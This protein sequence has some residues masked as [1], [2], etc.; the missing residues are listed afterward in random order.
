MAWTPMQRRAIQTRG[1]N[2]IVSAGA[3]SGKTAVLSERILEYC[4]DGHDIRNVLV[5]TF[6]NAAAL[7][8]KERIRQK[9]LTHHLTDQASYIDSA[10]I[11]TFDAYSL[12][13]VK[14]YY[15]H[16]GIEKDVSVIDQSLLEVQKIKFLDRLF[17]QLYQTKNSDFFDLLKKYAKQNDDAVKKMVFT[18]YDKLILEVDEEAF[19]EHYQEKYGTNQSIHQCA[20]DYEKLVKSKIAL[21]LQEVSHL[22]GLCDVE[23][24][25]RLKEFC[26]STIEKLSCLNQYESIYNA[27]SSL[28]FPRVSPKAS[29]AVKEQKKKCSDLLKSIQETYLSKYSTLEASEEELQ[30]LQGNIQFLFKLVWMLREEIRKYEYQQNAFDYMDIAKMAIDLVTKNEQVHKDICSNLEEILIDEYQDTSDIQEAF[31]QAIS[32]HNCMMV[33]DLKQSIY[34]FRNANPYIFKQ[35]Y[36]LYSEDI[37]GIKLDLTHN[38]RSRKEVLEDI[39]LIFSDLMTEACGDVNYSVNHQMHFGQAAYED[40]KAKMDYHLDVLTYEPDFSFSDEEV[41]AFI[42]ANKIKQMMNDQLTCLGKQGFRPVCYQDFAILID[43]TK[44]FVTFKKVFEYVGIPLAIEADLDLNNSIL[45]RL[46]ANL[47]NL[48]SK[49]CQNQFDKSYHH[50]LCSIGRSF[51]FGYSDNEIYRLAN[52]EHYENELTRK[53]DFLVGQ[54]NEISLTT[55][56]HQLVEQFDIYE[57][58]PLIGDVENSCVVLEYIHS[59]F[60]TMMHA[61]MDIHEASEYLSLVIDEGIALKYKLTNKSSDSVRIMTIHKSKGLEFPFC[62]FPMLSS[63]F[64]Q[65]DVKIGYGLSKQY[66]VY[67]PYCDEA[68]SHTIIKPLVDEQTKKNDLSEKVRLLYVA[69]TRAREKIILIS[70]EE[71]SPLEIQSFN[72]FI[73]RLK[74]LDDRKIKIDLKKL[75]LSKSY[76]SFFKATAFPTGESRCYREESFLSTLEAK[77]S[78]SKELNELVSDELS[79]AIALGKRF[80]QC[81]EVLDLAHPDIDGLPVDAYMKQTIR[82]VLNHPVFQSIEQA[83]AYHEYE[84]YFNEYHGIIDLLLVYEDHIDILDYKLSN[85]DSEEY[86]RQLSIYQ[87]YVTSISNL[88]THCYLISILKQEVKQIL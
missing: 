71:E 39:N 86:E 69:L 19:I 83:K 26:Q 1:N 18:I 3:G 49:K 60:E 74:F 85:L 21:W 53:I 48:I 81:L 44:S 8:M 65:A 28:S 25:L 15:F 33:G 43:K 66:G 2:L 55:L 54:I 77:K 22:E 67:I 16:L 6:T 31:I 61:A 23:D 70:K 14:K 64:N 10:A 4:L 12:S 38:F 29:E 13:L 57:K 37:G 75:G 78:I 79:K 73:Q 51:L 87:Q 82:K 41:E 35:K 45:P 50:A 36:D 30:Q 9:L 72:C 17:N 47:L 11:T 88:P 32:N 52:E 5:L 62:L 34:R 76:Q 40:A 68:S 7:E 59:L 46:F 42:C 58:L 80:H 63:R 20:L 27:L 56:F 84:F 24:D